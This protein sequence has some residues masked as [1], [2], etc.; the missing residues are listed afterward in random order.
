MTIQIFK[1]IKFLSVYK[2]SSLGY[3][4]SKYKKKENLTGNLSQQ[5]VH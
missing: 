3:K 1:N 2:N 4:S 5:L